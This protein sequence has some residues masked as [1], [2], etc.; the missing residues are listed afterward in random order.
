MIKVNSY[1]DFLV[2]KVY[3]SVYVGE[4][5]AYARVNGKETFVVIAIKPSLQIK[6]LFD[7]NGNVCTDDLC[8]NTVTFICPG[9]A[10]KE[11]EFF[12]TENES[13]WFKKSVKV[14][15]LAEAIKIGAKLDEFENQSMEWKS[16]VSFGNALYYYFSIE[17]TSENPYLQTI[18]VFWETHEAAS[19]DFAQYGATIS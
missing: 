9:K 8:G 3:N 19:Q 4:N 11:C 12:E 16:F 15:S 2:G 17:G 14:K 6:T 7:R 1:K 13:E 5:E 10:L 18:F